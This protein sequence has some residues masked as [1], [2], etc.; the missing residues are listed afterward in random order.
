[1]LIPGKHVPAVLHAYNKGRAARGESVAPGEILTAIQSDLMFRIP[2]TSLA[3]AQEKN[4]GP[5][6][7]YLF[8]W[9]SPIM[10]GA[11]GACHALEIGFV[12]GNHEDSFCGTGPLADDLSRKIQDAWTAFA[13]KGS[14][15]C[16]ILGEWEPYGQ[17]RR[18]MILDTQCR[19]EDAPCEEERSVWDDLDIL[20]TKPI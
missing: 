10:D 19:L 2:A 12:F 1:M 6:Y 17:A 16:D 3:S 18:T 11:L 4:G 13:R 7:A 15:V 9:K 8:K 20:F 14:P 5:V